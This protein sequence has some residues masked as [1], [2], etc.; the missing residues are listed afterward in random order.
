MQ[1]P[2]VGVG[3]VPVTVVRLVTVDVEVVVRLLL[4]CKLVENEQR[5]PRPDGSQPAVKLLEG[6]GVSDTW[7]DVLVVVIAVEL[8]LELAAG[9]EHMADCMA[10]LSRY[11]SSSEVRLRLLQLTALAGLVMSALAASSPMYAMS[12]LSIACSRV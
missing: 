5:G 3:A 4:I 9:G 6:D 8:D 7:L 11:A 12:R 2:V 1:T 10:R